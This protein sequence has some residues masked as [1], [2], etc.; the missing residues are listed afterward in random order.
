VT[1]SCSVLVGGWH[2]TH[3]AERGFGERP[4]SEGHSRFVST[5]F[6]A[7]D[8]EVAVAVADDVASL[9][10]GARV[11][12]FPGHTGLVGAMAVG[13]LVSGSAIEQV[14]GLGGVD[15]H[16]DALVDTREF[17]RPRVEAGRLVLR[18][19]PAADGLLVPFEQPHPTP[20]CVDHG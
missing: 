14:L 11:F 19:R 20:C 9:P 6:A 3:E 12:V 16:A 5:T 10:E 13:D 17:V 4:S 2:S 7:G 15:P 8:R 18:V 1:Q